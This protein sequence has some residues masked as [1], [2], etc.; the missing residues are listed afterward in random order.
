[1][2]KKASKHKQTNK[3]QADKQKHTT[4]VYSKEN[5]VRGL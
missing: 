5:A 1:M 4:V 2:T 3:T